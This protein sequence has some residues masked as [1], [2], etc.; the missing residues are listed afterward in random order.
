MLLPLSSSSRNI[1]LSSFDCLDGETWIGISKQH[2]SL[3]HEPDGA[4]IGEVLKNMQ[5]V[6]DVT[7]TLVKRV[8]NGRI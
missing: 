1:N 8:I 5:M 3:L 4:Y 6:T 2:G 7:E